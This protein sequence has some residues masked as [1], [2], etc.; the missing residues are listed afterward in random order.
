MSPS[1]YSLLLSFRQQVLVGQRGA[2]TQ[3]PTLLLE[4]DFPLCGSCMPFAIC[5]PGLLYVV[6]LSW[7]VLL[8]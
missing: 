5:A 3:V 7:L 6:V 8:L 2:G 4:G 1:L